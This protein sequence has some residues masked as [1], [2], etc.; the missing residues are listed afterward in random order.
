MMTLMMM[1]SILSD[2]LYA[3]IIM[4][5][6]RLNHDRLLFQ[7]KVAPQNCYTFHDG[8]R[9]HRAAGVVVLLG[10]PNPPRSPCR[11]SDNPQSIRLSRPFCAFVPKGDVIL[12]RRRRRQRLLE[13]ARP[14]RRK[15]LTNSGR[16]RP[17][18]VRR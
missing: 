8:G 10:V 18:W 6:C 11:P 3:I 7:G 5:R 14:A 17:A 4:P 16:G 2:C 15:E 13:L 12:F 1:R 9:S